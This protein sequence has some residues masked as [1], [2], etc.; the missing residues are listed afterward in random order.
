[1][2]DKD[3]LNERLARLLEPEPGPVPTSFPLWYWGDGMYPSPLGW[4][5]TWGTNH[6][7]R[8]VNFDDG[9]I[10]LRLIAEMEQRE[11]RFD[12]Q[13]VWLPLERIHWAVF[14]HGHEAYPACDVDIPKA[15]AEAAVKALEAGK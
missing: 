3:D 5:G 9:R 2:D 1:M 8:S 15:V 7:W 10:M 12:L 11:F 14:H 13:I 6:A 4:W